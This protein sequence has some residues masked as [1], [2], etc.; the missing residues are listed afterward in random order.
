MVEKRYAGQ[1]KTQRDLNTLI[2]EVAGVQA[3]VAALLRVGDLEACCGRLTLTS[4]VPVTT[5]DVTAAGTLYFTP[6]KGNRLA[7]YTGEGWTAHTFAELSLSLAGWPAN[8]NFDIFI[9]DNAGTP[10][11]EGVAWT[12]ATTR[13]TALA[14]QDGVYVK[15]G[16][17][18]RRYLGTVRTVAAGQC[19]DS[20]ARRFV[21]NYYNRV[22]R[23]LR[24]IEPT[25]SWTYQ[26]N[27]WRPS[28]NNTA[29]GV[30]RVSFVVGVAETLV[31]A[32]HI[33]WGQNSAASS[34]CPAGIALDATNTNHAQVLVG[35]SGS[36]SNQ[37]GQEAHGLWRGWP[38]AG[39]HYLQRTER[40]T[41]TGGTTTW[42]GYTSGVFQVG[43]TVEM[44]A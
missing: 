26:V 14:L 42:R 7:L 4:G 12:D 10:T 21:W 23:E 11:L 18:T 9:Y 39:H 15:A 3:E 38:A 28:N 35:W 20:T 27:A 22:T 24:A 8:T 32:H 1:N 19:E 40:S 25:A 5:R 2:D 33:A 43:M 29:D 36:G 17:A 6:Y 31:R 34:Y 44:E 13:A 41:A 16:A 30:G 37:F